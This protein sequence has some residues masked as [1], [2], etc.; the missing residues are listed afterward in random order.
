[1]L[2]ASA[3][4]LGIDGKIGDKWDGSVTAEGARVTSV[5]PWRF[6]AG[7]AMGA[8][9]SWKASIHAM[10]TVRRRADSG[11]SRRSRS[12]TAC[13]CFSTRPSDNAAVNVKT[14]SGDFRVSLRDIPW[15]AFK[16][17]LDGKVLVDRVP[18]YQQITNSPEE[19]DYPSA[20]VAKDGSVW[21]SY[22]EF[23]H[24]PDYVKVRLALQD[25]P[26]NFD[27]YSEKPG[28]DQVFARKY[29]NGAW[30]A[31]IA[32]SEAG[33]DMWRP[34]IAVDGSDRPWVFWSSNK[35]TTGVANYDVYAR[36]VRNGAPGDDR[37]TQQRSRLRCRPGRCH[38]FHR[39]RVGRV[40]GLAQW[41]RQHPLRRTGW[42][43]L[44]ASLR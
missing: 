31:P 42:R 36:P 22:L 12:P 11:S 4:F 6:D 29:S 20:A 14:A 37:A 1:M 43:R 13:S 35:S 28:G 33:G 5:E 7:D 34:S 41:T 18:G 24:A 8:D 23:K 9:H 10:R 38:R 16:A 25:A 39:P 40:A 19:Q 17:E 32:I 44:S 3:S 27:R 21:I 26:A 2:S 15:G 30:G